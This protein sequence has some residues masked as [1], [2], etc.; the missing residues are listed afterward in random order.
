MNEAIGKPAGEAIY[1][2]NIEGFSADGLI[3]P[4]SAAGDHGG[5][6]ILLRG[7]HG[8]L[9]SE[10]LFSPAGKHASPLV[11]KPGLKGHYAIFLGQFCPR[12]AHD[13]QS[14]DRVGL[15]IRLQRDRHYTLLFG[16]T[17][18]YE[19]SHFKTVE[20][21][22]Y[23]GIEVASFDRAAFF[24]FIKL[25]PVEKPVLPA[26]TGRL[27]GMCDFGDDAALSFPR[28]FE[29]GSCVW[30]HAEAGFDAILWKAYSVRCEYH[31]RVGEMREQA[32]GAGG[33]S[34]GDCLQH[35][36]TLQQAVD[37]AHKAGVGIYGWARIANEF[38]PRQDGSTHAHPGFMPTTNFHLANPDKVMLRKDGAPSPKLSFAYPEVRRHKTAILC[39]IASYGVD[40]ICVDVLRHPPMALYDKPLV[41]EFIARTGLDPR[42]MDGDGSGEWLKFKASAFTAFLRETRA[43]LREQAGSRMKLMVRT[44][45]LPW[46][47][48]VAGCDVRGWIEEGIVDEII[49]S[50][51]IPTAECFPQRLDIKNY[52]DMAGDRVGVFASVWRYGSPIEA[53][54]LAADC[55]AQ[56][57]RGV[58]FY[59]SNAAVETPVLRENLWRFSR[60]GSLRYRRME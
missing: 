19:E 4:E 32:A 27:I 10:L 23:D 49:F 45:E 26:K 1:L 44:M 52:V 20:L 50:P 17:N 15:Y 38:A 16:R 14:A 13:W 34:L 12:N 46:R 3:A 33:Y 57:A 48:M 53:E 58:M 56:G 60:P 42:L 21:S 54:A 41:D 39:E 7:R 43:A 30:R 8:A 28:G 35:Y 2:K 11:F 29:A 25:L 31:T 5:K 24:D 36:D 37:E 55:Y 59:E 40:G 18:D 22:P 6:W 51:H 9:N 47:N